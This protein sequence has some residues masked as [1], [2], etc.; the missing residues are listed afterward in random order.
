TSDF[1]RFE[2]D[3]VKEM[4]EIVRETSGKQHILFVIDEVGQYVAAREHLILNLDGLAKNLKTIGG[5]KVWIIATAQ[6]TLTEDD[7]RAAL[8]S[9]L[10]FKLS[11]RFP[12]QLD[13]EAKDI[14][15]IC[16]RRLLG[17]SPAGEQTL[18]Q[19]FEQY[20]PELRHNTKLQNAK[21]YNA[22]FDKQ[23]FTNLYPFLPAQFDILLQLLGALARWTG[24][25]GL[26]SAIKVVQDILIEGVG[27]TP[28]ADQPVDWL[29]TTVTLYDALEKDIRRA[30]PSIHKAVEKIALRFHGSPLHQ[31]IAKTVAVLQI[32]DNI[33]VSL[34]N[35]AA[36][37]HPSLASAS[38]LGEIE[39]AVREM[40]DDGQS[41]FSEKEGGLR[42]LSEKVSEIEQERAA[43]P[44]RAI[45]SQR[46]LNAALTSGLS[47]LPSTKLHS[48]LTVTSGL[49][50][51]VG[52]VLHALAG[53]KETVQTIVEWAAAEGY[54]AARTRL[55][56]ESRQ[57]SAQ[58]TVFW[59][60][61]QAEKAAE[62][63]IEIYRSEEIARRHHN[64]PDQEVR[65]YC[66][67]QAERAKKLAD[68]LGREL[69]S[70]LRQGSLIFRGQMT[71]VESLDASPLE[72]A[73]KHLAGVAEQVFDR[74]TE[75]PVRAD[76]SLAEKFLKLGSLKSATSETD[77]LN[78]VQINGGAARINAHHKALTSIHDYL[79]QGGAVDGKRLSEHFSDAPFGWSPDTLR[80]LV[81]A[82]LVNGEVRLKISGREIKVTGQQA[83]EGL[84]NN[85]SF[86]TVGIALRDEQLSP[87]VLARAA[88]RL[89]ELIGDSVD[90]LEQEISKAAA[91][92]FPGFQKNYSSLESRLGKLGLPGAD[93]MHDL[94]N[95]LADILASDASDLPQRLGSP[96]SILYNN[97]KWAAAVSLALKNGL[98]TTIQGLREH[99]A[100]ISTLPEIGAPGKLRAAVEET[101]QP[102]AERLA[103]ENFHQYGA[104]L[105][106]ALTKI[107]NHVRDATLE[108]IQEQA[109][110]LH[111]FR[112]S[113]AA[114]PEWQEFTLAEQQQT[115]AEVD[116]WAIQPG[117]NLAGFRQLLNHE[118]TLQQRSQG[119]KAKLVAEGRRRIEERGRDSQVFEKQI[120]VAATL[121]DKGRLAALVETLEQ[122]QREA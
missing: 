45:E 9:P 16:Y 111:A 103:Q 6:Q 10:L 34:Q 2:T 62:Q 54:E 106:T 121:S 4:L 105:N 27:Q 21:Y 84:R 1:V 8:N 114:L 108:L 80:Y 63:A 37:S 109:Q 102:I 5:G 96:E 113:L 116:G 107:R 93:D 17:K 13:L 20:G 79:N 55:V 44:V 110:A 88:Q 90:P 92:H 29:V 99:W 66:T 46:I 64:D 40:I 19:R 68:D 82:M 53:E 115:L 91:L 31:E 97:L 78:L 70:H 52:G 39:A 49:K 42:L 60:G 73:R 58:Y 30:A 101:L 74:Y 48:T 51:Q 47:P 85:N 112:Q 120:E 35:V 61:R 65:D 28:V 7:P 71:A 76:T 77:P 86:K 100:E 118:Y 32:L 59:L 22:D 50:M 43:I 12:I 94:T 14:K 26:R 24:G 98:E 95:D 3:R 83:I 57:R 75:A 104:D 15:E 36:L 23:V 33:P 89:S 81:A 56:E 119:Q 87:E 38:R 41:P 117:H 25:I 18:A 11:A 67:G 72:A 69:L 122:T